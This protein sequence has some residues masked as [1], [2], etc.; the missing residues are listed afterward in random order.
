MK[1]QKTGFVAS[2][3]FKNQDVFSLN[4]V[5]KMNDIKIRRQGLA[6]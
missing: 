5:H 4:E 2:F 1:I 3:W 6:V